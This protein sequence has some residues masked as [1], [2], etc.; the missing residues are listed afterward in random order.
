MGKI[1]SEV[2]IAGFS[3]KSELLIASF[4]KLV[5]STGVFAINAGIKI[6]ILKK[7]FVKN[8]P[9]E[10]SLVHTFDISSEKKRK[11]IE[12]NIIL[13]NWYNN[14]VSPENMLI[15]LICINTP[16]TDN[17]DPP[18]TIPF[19]NHKSTITIGKHADICLEAWDHINGLYPEH[20]IIKYNPIPNSNWSIQSL[21]G[22]RRGKKQVSI[23]D[24][25]ISAK[26]GEYP[27]SDGDKLNLGEF[28]FIFKADKKESLIRYESPKEMIEKIE[29]NCLWNRSV[30]II[31][32][33]IIPM[34]I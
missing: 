7:S 2:T 23:N 5:I 12:N 8:I 9:Y 28:K 21:H 19:N 11:D 26:S 14:P 18:T 1:I 27:L 31:K 33:I 32:I 24:T 4:D 34:I 30:Y 15:G 6:H 16:I 29:L 3:D 17:I 25:I 10:S 20:V 22:F 13:P